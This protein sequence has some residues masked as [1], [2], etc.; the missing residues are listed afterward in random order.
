MA[1]ILLASHGLRLHIYGY[2]DDVGNEAYNQS[3]SERRAQAVQDYL[4]KAG[5]RAYASMKSAIRT[6][7]CGTSR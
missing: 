6:A 3:L 7:A 2:T 4:A 5:P 1:G